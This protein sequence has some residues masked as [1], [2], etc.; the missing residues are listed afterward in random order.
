MND[1][2]KPKNPNK[3]LYFDG[4]CPMCTVYSSAFKQTGI[5]STEGTAHLN[6]ATSLIAPNLDL[7]RARHEIPLVDHSTG[8]VEYGIDSLCALLSSIHP[9]IGWLIKTFRLRIIL[10]PLYHLISFNRRILSGSKSDLG[11]APDFN[12]TYRLSWLVFAGLISLGISAWAGS[13]MIPAFFEVSSLTAALMAC[14]LV[15][16]AWII[17]SLFG[18]LKL[19]GIKRWDYFGQLFTVM[20]LGVIVWLP[21]ILFWNGSVSLIMPLLFTA[22]SFTL[23]ANAWYKRVYTL[24]L[25]VKWFYLWIASLWISAVICTFF[26]GLTKL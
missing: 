24:E 8:K 18:L 3:T 16:P 2:A 17:M 25:S 15:G 4:D 1:T 6:G 7:Q 23:M 26:L 14:A 13:Q 5:L 9:I 11:M 21:G 19:G 22:I 20:F 10:N 12:F